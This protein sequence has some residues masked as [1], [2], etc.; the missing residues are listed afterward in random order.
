MRSSCHI[1]CAKRF[2]KPLY[3][4]IR[5]TDNHLNPPLL[6]DRPPDGG[7]I[8]KFLARKVVKMKG[9]IKEGEGERVT[10]T[11]NFI[12]LKSNQ[13]STYKGNQT[14]T[15]LPPKIID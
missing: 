15:N 5:I 14:I 1:G 2:P 8:R 12:T 9:A 11:S 3:Y 10:L 13:L 7:L 6:V 4:W